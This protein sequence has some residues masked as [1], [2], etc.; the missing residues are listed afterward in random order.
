[1]EEQAVGGRAAA[2]G[3]A[4]AAA[5]GE[6][7]GGGGVDSEGGMVTCASRGRMPTPFGGTRL[8]VSMFNI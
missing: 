4:R 5:R 2:A 1:M 3:E 8:N 7:G 6:R